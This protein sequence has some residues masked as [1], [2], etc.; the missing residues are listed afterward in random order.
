MQQ[1]LWISEAKLRHNRVRSG[2]R[3]RHDQARRNRLRHD[4]FER[5]NLT[6][7]GLRKIAIMLHVDGPHLRC[8]GHDRVHRG[9][10][11]LSF[12]DTAKL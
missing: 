4:P 8:L 3:L 7:V 11:L 12:G 6:C 10:K 5:L 1:A 2:R 9:G